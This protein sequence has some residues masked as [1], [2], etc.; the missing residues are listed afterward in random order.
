MIASWMRD[1]AQ[2]EREVC[3]PRHAPLLAA[4]QERVPEVAHLTSWPAVV[5][6]IQTRGVRGPD[7]DC[8]LR[9]LTEIHA[10]GDDDKA[11]TVLLLLCLTELIKL[12]RARR[13]WMP[14][15]GR[16]WRLIRYCF[17][18]ALHRL[19]PAKRPHRLGQKLLNDT[20]RAFYDECAREWSRNARF[21]TVDP[22]DLEDSVGMEDPAFEE[23]ERRHTRER[24]ARRV[25]S[26]AAAGAICL[27]DSY[28]VLGTRIYGVRLRGA[29]DQLGIGYE[30]AKKRRQR[31]EA[32][33]RRR[34]S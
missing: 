9:P 6:L 17:L 5:Q 23:F 14:G 16:R 22:H 10:A 1:R 27:R 34:K 30:A 7:A 11:S 25:R 26:A 33:L 21:E 24:A 19:D 20:A 29:A 12:H 18:R 31:A 28:L 15:Q 4:L 8:V 32:A 3:R 13:R 2:L